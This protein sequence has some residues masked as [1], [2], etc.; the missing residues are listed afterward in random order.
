MYIRWENTSE[1]EVVLVI[2]EIGKF[3]GKVDLFMLVDIID[4]HKDTIEEDDDVYFFVEKDKLFSVLN[5]F[6]GEKL[7]K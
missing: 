5:S 4:D 1:E 7:N 6:S 3:L 2:D